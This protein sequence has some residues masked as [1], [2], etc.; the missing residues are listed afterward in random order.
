MTLVRDAI[1]AFSIDEME[2]SLRFNVP[3]Y[4]LSI[5]TTD[6]IVSQLAADQ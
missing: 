1:G 2:A 5:V 4:A 6:E 3:I